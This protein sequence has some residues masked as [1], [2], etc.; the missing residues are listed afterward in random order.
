MLLLP[1]T[2]MI[3][4]PEVLWSCSSLLDTDV[5]TVG[6]VVVTHTQIEDS[7]RNSFL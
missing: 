5:E 6:D 2:V 3:S 1:L 7:S 4:E